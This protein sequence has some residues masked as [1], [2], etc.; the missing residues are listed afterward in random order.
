MSDNLIQIFLAAAEHKRDAPLFL[1]KKDGAWQPTTGAQA[2]ETVENLAHGLE[3]LGVRRGDRVAIFAESRVEWALADFAI[4]GIGA[5][6]VPIYAT[7]TGP[8]CAALLRNSGAKVAIVSNTAQRDKL[9]VERGSAPDLGAIIVM[10][11]PRDPAHTGEVTWADLIAR[12]SEQRQREP[13]LFQRSIADIV[14]NDLATIIY[15]SGTT[16]EPKGAMLSHANIASNVASALKVFG[17]TPNDTSL[18]FLPLS[19]IFERMGGLYCMLAGGVTIAYAESLEAVSANAMEVRPTI[20]TGVPRFYEKVYARVM[21]GGAARPPIA[22]ALFHWAL[23]VGAQRA[24]AKFAGRSLSPLLAFQLGIADRLVLSK[25]RARVGGRLRYGVSGGAPLAPNVMEFF[26][27]I[28][29]PIVEGYGLTETSPVITLNPPGSEIPGSVGRAVPGVEV[30][31][32]AE[33]E[34]LTRGPHVMLGYYNNTEATKAVIRD[35]WFHT[36]DVGRIDERGYMYITDRLK[37]LLVTAGGKK[38][39]PQPVEAA[40]KESRWITEAV[41]LGD[42]RPYIVCL[43]IPNF[44]ALEAEAPSRG[45]DVT[46]RARFLAQPD[47]RALFQTELDRV[48]K[49]RSSFEQVK[50][51]ALLENELTQADGEL[52]PSLKVKRRVVSERYKDQIEEM[53]EAPR[54]RAAV[55]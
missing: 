10:D 35:G 17:L 39:A 2:I 19:H 16:G 13:D 20:I 37:D 8:Q 31:I 41:L 3:M 28:G 32:G 30:K 45:W 18:S 55:G 6:T 22:R 29:I 36:G 42:R 54:E 14:P 38:V 21:E 26:F 1:S 48:N 5:V 52:T 7:V 46:D 11:G 27:S 47:V 40:L 9:R 15:T 23:G 24:R 44:V 34:I 43:L 33:G 12:G 51:F 4:L 53:Y 49:G 25:I 50:K